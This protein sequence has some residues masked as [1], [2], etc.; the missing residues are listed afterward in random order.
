MRGTCV[1]RHAGGAAQTM[2]PPIVVTAPS[3]IRSAP[4]APSAETSPAVAPVEITVTPL[5]PVL[6]ALPIVTGAVRD[7]HR[8]A[9]RGTAPHAL[10][11]ARRPPVRQTRHHRVELRAGRSL[12]SDHPRSR[13]QP[14]RHYG[15]RNRRG[16]RVR[17]RRG[18]FRAGHAACHDPGRGDPRARDAALRLTVDRRRG[19]R[20]QQPH[21]GARSP[22][23]RRAS[24]ARCAA[25]PP[26]STAGSR[27]AC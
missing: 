3:P 18:P 9:E 19:E 21:S 6:G 15:E 12:A 10:G 22:A 8:R 2:L 27:A 11:H 5:A 14:R 25:P 7:R 24:P 23:P 13:R 20:D 17:S 4:P 1:T 26:Q 16:R